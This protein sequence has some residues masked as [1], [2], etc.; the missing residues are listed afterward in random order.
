MRYLCLAFACLLAAFPLKAQDTADIERRIA[1]AVAV[2]AGDL[3]MEQAFTRSFISAV[4][5]EQFRALA[6]QFSGRYGALLGVENVEPSGQTGAAYI[7]LRYEKAIARGRIQLATSLPYRISGL[8]IQTFEPVNEG[9]LSVTEQIAALPGR[10]AIHL[11]R[12][13][14]GET[15]FSYNSGLSL[16]IGSTF[17]LYVL[18]ALSRSIAAG[19]RDWTDVVEL[20]QPSLSSGILHDWPE[21]TPVTL[22]TLA[23][24]MISISDNTATDQLIAELGRAAVEAELVASGHA[25]PASTLP[26]LTTREL[27]VLKGGDDTALTNYARAELS[28]RRAILSSL[29]DTKPDEAAV[30]TAFA[31]G[32]RFL[33]VEWFASR[34]DIAKVFARLTDDPVALDIL[35]VNR[36]LGE[37]VAHAYDYVGYKGGSE[38]GVLDFS[39]LLRDRE[40]VWWMFS[41]GWNNSGAVVDEALFLGLANAAMREAAGQ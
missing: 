39:W 30:Q 36:V 38:P 31:S 41:M 24:L 3:P 40:G 37:E 20:D 12:L 15:I 34:Q 11:G 22:H 7:A 25:D 18:S 35:A 6:A 10:T 32:P 1:D 13:D 27:F 17:K 33:N 14:G 26:L 2:M 16:A 19:D 9:G 29:H 21:G 4:P 28:E 8:L 23:T 5:E